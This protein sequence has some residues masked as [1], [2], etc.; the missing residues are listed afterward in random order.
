MDG[1]AA[2]R[3][4]GGDARA[5]ASSSFPRSA[6]ERHSHTLCVEDEYMQGVRRK[7]ADAVRLAATHMETVE[8]GY[9]VG[10]EDRL[11]SNRRFSTGFAA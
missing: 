11:T 5:I 8:W 9:R 4:L 10:H 2:G 1:F 6:W 7:I 3:A